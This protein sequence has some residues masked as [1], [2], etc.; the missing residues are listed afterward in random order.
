M[1]PLGAVSHR[2][3]ILEIK[4]SSGLAGI[5][6]HL[7]LEGK[8]G[9]R[10]SC[11]WLV[12]Q[13]MNS[14]KYNL[15]VLKN[16]MESYVRIGGRGLKNLTYP[17]I[18]SEWPLITSWRVDVSPLPT[19]CYSTHG[20]HSQAA[21]RYQRDLSMCKTSRQV[22]KFPNFCLWILRLIINYAKSHFAVWSRYWNAHLVR[23]ISMGLINTTAT[24][25]LSLYG[26][27]Q[28][29]QGEKNRC[30]T[31][32]NVYGFFFLKRKLV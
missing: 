14:V 5:I 4:R 18:L 11:I 15:I 23:F 26:L 17:Y 27:I 3:F 9:I 30:P 24:H 2:Y 31:V 19:A 7:R 1:A 8:K 21:I 32:R 13:R 25:S 22:I 6:F 16:E 12:L 10:M 20:R 28:G 29:R